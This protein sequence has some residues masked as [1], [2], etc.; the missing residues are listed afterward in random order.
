MY[1]KSKLFIV[2][3]IFSTIYALKENYKEEKC[4]EG[5]NNSCFQNEINENEDNFNNMFPKWLNDISKNSPIS[6]SRRRRA[7]LSFP[8]YSYVA[9]SKR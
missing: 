7:F 8:R 3:F 5:K 6:K 2:T 9:V 1:F 4:T